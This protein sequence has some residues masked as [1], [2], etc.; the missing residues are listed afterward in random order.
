MNAS[1]VYAKSRGLIGTDFDDSWSGQPYFDSPNWH[2]NRNGNFNLERRYQF[3]LQ[4][5][6][7]GPLGINIGA[8]YRLLCGNRYQRTIGSLDLG[9]DLND[10]NVSIFAEKRGTRKYPDLSILD[11]H[12]EKM[13]KIGKIRLSVFADV[14]NLFNVNTATDIYELS[15]TSTTINGIPVVFGDT[16][17]IYDP[18]RIFRLG[19]RIEF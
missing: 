18:P 9:L 13:F 17:E 3:K 19:T 12:L 7:R 2:I 15:S 8:Y 11:M 14:F 4:A 16:E 1:Y 5:L 10:G 6:V